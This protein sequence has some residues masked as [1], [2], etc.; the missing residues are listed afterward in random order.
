[1]K[2]RT[3]SYGR[4]LRLAFPVIVSQLGQITVSLVD[5]IMIGR[6]GTLELAAASFVNNIFNLAIFFGM[7]ITF[8]I[9]P[10]V[11]ESI[12]KKDNQTSSIFKNA[13]MVAT[14]TAVVIAVLLLILCLFFHQMGQDP[15]IIQMA[16][17]YFLLLI[18]SYLPLML[19]N[20][21]KQFAEG[22]GDTKTGMY[23]IIAGNLVNIVGNYLFIYGKMGVSP[24]GLDGAAIGTILS[25]IF[26]LLAFFYLFVFR[27]RYGTWLTNFTASSI[28]WELA[29]KITRKGVML[30]L[31]MLIEAGA[32]GLAGIMIGWMGAPGLAA[33]QIAISLSSLGFM[34][35]QGLGSATTILVSQSFGAGSKKRMLIQAKQSA[36]LVIPL[37]LI[38]AL[39]FFIFRDALPLIF[40]N[41]TEVIRITSTLLIILALFQLPDALQI[42]YGSAVRAMTDVKL[43]VIFLFISYF[44]VSLPVGYLFA[45]TFKYQQLGIWLAF[46]I[47]VSL[48]YLF[49][50]FRFKFLLKRSTNNN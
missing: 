35:Y 7:V 12:G 3:I 41:D 30:G 5:N 19:F 16:K 34:V 38:T 42:I 39:F 26:M 23:I 14:I 25:R 13:L 11:G 18:T 37:S 46:P 4:I 50:K 29:T 43:P 47:G 6:L 2:A 36:I 22:T 20:A 49:L 48:A 24:M 15:A 32:F 31:Q 10:L 8:I 45:F 21:F 28:Q 33:H 44:I 9:T 27:K 1:M 40:S 17:S